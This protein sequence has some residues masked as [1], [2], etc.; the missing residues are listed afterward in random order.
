MTSVFSDSNQV[1]DELALKNA[2]GETYK[3]W[4]KIF[5]FTLDLQGSA[6]SEWKYSGKRF[7][8]S[9]RVSDKKRV[10]IYLLPRAGFFRVAMVFGNKAYDYI[11]Q[12]NISESI[13]L[14]LAQAPV[15]AEG[16]G[17]RM[18]I[19]DNDKWSDIQSL[20]QI[21]IQF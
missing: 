19:R 3:I 5:Q 14:E 9:F 13:K 16:R 11:Q 15:N 18:E 2:L 1:P 20:I 4:Q 12:S 10:L 21:K 8:W 17:I 7:G 6:Q